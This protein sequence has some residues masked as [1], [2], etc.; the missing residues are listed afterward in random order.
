MIPGIAAGTYSIHVRDAGNTAIVGVSNSFTVQAPS[1]TLN[2]LPSTITLDGLLD[3]SGLV[4]PAGDTVQIGFSASAT[5]SPTSWVTAT[6][7]GNV[8]SGS[9]TPSATGAFYVWAQ[10]TNAP[11]VNV[12]SAAITVVQ[13]SLTVVGPETGTAGAALAITG[14]VVPA[15]DIVNIQLSTSN[16]AMP[17]SGWVAASNN[18][19]SISGS[20]TPS[21]AGTFYVWAQDPASGLTA[22]SSAIAVNAA[23]AVVYGFNNPGGSYAHGSGTIGLNGSVSPAQAMGTQVS[24]STSNTTAPASGWQ[25]ASIIDSNALW[26]VYYTTP[27]E[28]GN[29]YIWVQTTAGADTVV[30]SFTV[31]VT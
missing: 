22:V 21:D 10:Q 30:S 18:N 3:V 8:W 13:A 11:S 2:V 14:S 5:V 29:Y 25:A 6:V 28:V 4:S 20:L 31:S 7:N 17:T 16:V 23:A 15:S 12:V 26:A 9:V 19:G 1:V 27:A 24:L